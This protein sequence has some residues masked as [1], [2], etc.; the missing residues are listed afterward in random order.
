M[1]RALAG[2]VSHSVSVHI[3]AS[4]LIPGLILASDADECRRVAA[5]VQSDR[6]TVGRIE[7]DHVVQRLQHVMGT[8][9]EI[10]I[11]ARARSSALTASEAATRAVAEADHRLSTWR[12]DSELSA[13][14][15]RES[16]RPVELSVELARDLGDSLDW[17][18]RTSGFFSPTLGALVSVWDLRGAGR[19]PSDTEL[20]TALTASS[21]D[22]TILADRTLRFGRPDVLFEEGGFGK[23]AALRDALDAALGSGAQCVVVD[24]GGHIAVGGDCGPQSISIS[25]PNNRNREIAELRLFEGSVA[26][27]GLSER[28]IVVDGVRYGHILDPRSGSPAPDWGTV[29]V[30]DPDP[31]AADCLATALYVMGPIRGAEWLREH[32]DIDAIFVEKNGPSIELIATPGLT[33]RLEHFEGKVIYLPLDHQRM[34]NHSH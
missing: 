1:L 20:R 3:L 11:R 8:T 18:R 23:G 15:N 9:L 24:F 10:T 32:T 16:S 28:G 14:N 22:G 21:I 2:F 4:L 13:V 27:S 12:D 19:I 6:G 5:N 34:R 17:N 30:V 29:T 33:G 26:T 31:F 7:A 25:D